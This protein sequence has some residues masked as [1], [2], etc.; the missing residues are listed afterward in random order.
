[1]EGYRVKRGIS[2]LVIA[3][4]FLLFGCGEDKPDQAPYF[5]E[6]AIP[7][8]TA[9]L[10][11]TVAAKYPH[12]VNAFTEGLLFHEGKLFESTGS[13][14]NMP[15][16]RSVFGIVDL[17]SGKIDV[18]GEIDRSFFGEGICIVGDTLFQVTWQKQTGFI[19]D[20]KTY[21]RIGQFS[22]PNRE[23]WGLTTDGKSLIMSDG[24]Y[25][26]TWFDPAALKV[27]K[28]LAVTKDGYGVDHL[29]ELEWVDGFIYANIWMTSRIVKIDPA[30]GV[31][32]A[33]G[34]FT[35]LFREA[36]RENPALGEMNGI[37]YDA[38]TGHLLLTGKMWPRI[39]AVKLES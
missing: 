30:T 35:E 36:E 21:K 13:P 11:Y 2:N 20:A 39:F 6:P 16:L 23:G 18:K 4:S 7:K 32:V 15:K 10:Q 22:Y 9:A 34:D 29:N 37:A 12:D 31:V 24:T 3:G 26:L 33:E 38:S 8:T 19:Y 1:M 28:T 14:D 25:N 17:K 27:T 5:P